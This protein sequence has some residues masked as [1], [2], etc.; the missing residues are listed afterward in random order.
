M[1]GGRQ[2][3]GGRERY[4]GTKRLLALTSSG[5]VHSALSDFCYRPQKRTFQVFK[6]L[7]S[8]A[9][10]R[11]TAVFS[12]VIDQPFQGRAM[13]I[14]VKDGFYQTDDLSDVRSLGVETK[15]LT[16]CVGKIREERIE[17]VFGSPYFGF[18]CKHLDFLRDVPWVESVWFWDVALDSIDG[19]YALEHLRHFGVHPKRPPIDFSRFPR[20]RHAVVHPKARD[21]GLDALQELD[22]LHIWHYRPASGNFSGLKI[23]T[24]LT[25]LQINWANPASLETLTA[26]PDLRRLEIHQCRHLEDLGL[27]GDRFPKLEHLVVSACPRLSVENAKRSIAGLQWLSHAFVGKVKIR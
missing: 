23:P 3:L 12:G 5:L 13:P 16:E 25:E 9:C 17:G 11:P 6:L 24:S 18:D 2:P 4:S 27:L 22:L 15:R 14:A 21:T 19:L 10:L 7:P 1:G 8:A 20:L 26:L